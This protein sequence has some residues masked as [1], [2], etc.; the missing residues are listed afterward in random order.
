MH[1]WT[2][3]IRR[4][5]S[6]VRGSLGVLL[7]LGC[8]AAGVE[9]RPRGP[10]LAPA[11]SAL[12]AAA[13]EIIQEAPYVVLATNTAGGPPHLRLM[14]PLP[15]DTAFVVWLGTNPRSRKVAEI[16]RDPRVTLFYQAS[17]GT[18]YVMLSGEA[19]LIDDAARKAVHWKD[20]WAP[21]YPDRARDLLLIE[22]RPRR[23][24]VVNYARDV[25]GDSLTWAAP[26]GVLGGDRP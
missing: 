16:R 1:P 15:P 21:F 22:V 18:G 11:D 8:G 20:A 24:E 5:G 4:S 13:R 3:A 23:L 9:E 26:A 12:R 17:G 2:D 10:G 7:A 19:R 6:H 25:V 14:D